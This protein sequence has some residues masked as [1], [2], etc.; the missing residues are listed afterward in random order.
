MEIPTIAKIITNVHAAGTERSPEATG[1]KGLLTLH[2]PQQSLS[3]SRSSNL[4]FHLSFV[5]IRAVHYQYAWGSNLIP[6]TLY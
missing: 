4:Y 3:P 2:A 5:H 6:A 1:K